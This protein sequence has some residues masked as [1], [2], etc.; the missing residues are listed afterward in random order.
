MMRSWS[1]VLFASSLLL[2]GGMILSDARANS[3]GGI[4][5]PSIH[6]TDMVLTLPYAPH[7]P[8][9]ITGMLQNNGDVPDLLLSAVSPL[10]ERAEIHTMTMDGDVMK[11]RPLTDGLPLDPGVPVSLS[12]TG[13]HIMCFGAH[14]ID[15]PVDATTI[16]FSFKKA[17][18]ITVP[19]FVR[20]TLSKPAPHSSEN[21]AHHTQSH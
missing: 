11:M 7:T 8:G 20:N 4:A 10:C 17:S 12:G 15:A 6:A 19:I 18:A 14:D 3:S 1:W 13:V 5:P 21:S 2:L 9:L 16:T